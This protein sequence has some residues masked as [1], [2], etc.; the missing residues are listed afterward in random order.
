MDRLSSG[1]LSL[2]VA[3][4]NTGSASAGIVFRT[5]A[6]G[7]VHAVW[8]VARVRVR[9]YGRGP[10]DQLP[11]IEFPSAFSFPSYAPPTPGTDSLTVEPCRLTAPG[12]PCGSWSMLYRTAF[13][14]S[15][16][17]VEILITI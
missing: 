2:M 16:S 7:I 9:G 12:K 13:R 10:W 6:S 3:T 14:A 4:S 5:G 17:V 11:A 15:A 8:L 1:L